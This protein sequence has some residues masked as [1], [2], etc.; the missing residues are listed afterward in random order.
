L[1]DDWGFDGFVMSDW[2]F[3]MHSTVA[4]A[5]AGTHLE[6]PF[7]SYFGEPLVEAVRRGEVDEAIVDDAV[8]RMLAKRL[9]FGLDRPTP[10]DPGA[11]A[12][13]EHLAL[14]REVAERGMVLLANRDAALPIGAEVRALAVVGALADQVNLGDK[15]S[16]SVVPPYAVTPLAGIQQR[17]QKLAIAHIA[18]DELDDADAARVAQSDAAIVVVGFTAAD[19]G[20]AILG[21]GGDRDSL[22]LSAAHAALVE[23]VTA[24]NARTIVVLEAGGAVEH[25]AWIDA[26]DA[27]VM[28][29]YPGVEG[30]TALASLV[31]GDV[32]PSGRL[33]MAFP[34]SEADLPPFDN[35][36]LEVSYGYLHGQRWLDAQGTAALFPLGF[37]LS[38][39]QF[40]Y[41]GLAL[42]A[43]ELGASDTL[44][45]R[46][47]VT[48]V[49][50]MAGEEVAQLYLSYPD[51]QVERAPSELRAFRRVRLEPGETRL[52]EL[53]VPVADLAYYDPTSSRWVLE[54]GELGVHVGRNAGDL[55]LSARARL[56]P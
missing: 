17:A 7:A 43:S 16:S 47:A 23:R 33:P 41:A 24:L 48:N 10:L 36:S 42:E 1:V 2:L 25:G 38:Y 56:A 13:P 31:F 11:V 52:V 12:T 32:S 20:E 8:R 21:S 9:A 22:A 27:L 49:G 44:V 35:R 19:E 46:F 45:A 4:A 51:A 53:A 37:G 14:A 3:A 39:T 26:A 54:P 30:G 5:K 15:G 29:W 18:R 28:A 6:M 55:P 50:A 34:V 40:S